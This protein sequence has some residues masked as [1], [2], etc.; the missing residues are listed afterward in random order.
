MLLPAIAR[1]QINK[2]WRLWFLYWLEYYSNVHV[3][4]FLFPFPSAETN[5][6]FL[7]SSIQVGQCNLCGLKEHSV[8]MV[9]EGL[10]TF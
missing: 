6:L 7:C 1:L 3:C 8:T 5:Q 10:G 2:T 4:G 9:A